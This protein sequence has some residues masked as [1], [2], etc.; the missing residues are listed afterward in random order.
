MGEKE[1]L[2]IVFLVEMLLLALS[3]GKLLKGYEQGRARPSSHFCLMA[4][5]PHLHV[6]IFQRLRI[7]PN[8]E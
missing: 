6:C 3:V 7:G 2:E 5:L 8:F 1:V 4:S